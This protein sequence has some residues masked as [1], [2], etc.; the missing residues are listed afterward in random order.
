M[1]GSFSLFAQQH[2]ARDSHD[3]G[4]LTGPGP[5]LPSLVCAWLLRRPAK[6]GLAHR[7]R[8]VRRKHGLCGRKLP[9]GFRLLCPTADVEAVHRGFQGGVAGLGI[10]N[11]SKAK[12]PASS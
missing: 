7:L 3:A 6:L 9:A 12:M 4:R 5:Q 2:V 11:L 8:R 10:R 1:Y